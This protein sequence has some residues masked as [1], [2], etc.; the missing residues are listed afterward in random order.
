MSD[1]NAPVKTL[2]RDVESIVTNQFTAFAAGDNVD[3]TKLAVLQK[4]ADN[5]IERFKQPEVWLQPLVI[6]ESDIF[7]CLLAI[8]EIEIP[9]LDELTTQVERLLKILETALPVSSSGSI[10]DSVNITFEP[11]RNLETLGLL[12]HIDGVMI[13][14]MLMFMEKN[15]DLA[16]N[17]D[18]TTTV[19]EQATLLKDYRKKLKDETVMAVEDDVTLLKLFAKTF[20]ATEEVDPYLKDLGR[21]NDFI[22][23][24]AAVA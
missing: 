11:N 1:V 19:T 16:V 4:K 20:K 15:I 13:D 10:T 24:R 21:Y 5:E 2:L 23:R 18:Y 9:E 12:S 3:K 14:V 6:E 22:E 7:S 8:N 17:S